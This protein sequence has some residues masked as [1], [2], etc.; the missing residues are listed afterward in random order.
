MDTKDGVPQP[1]AEKDEKGEK[2][3][4]GKTES[5][6]VPLQRPGGERSVQRSVGKQ[7]DIFLTFGADLKITRG[8]VLKDRPPMLARS[9]I[10]RND[11]EWTR[12]RRNKLQKGA[13]KDKG[14]KA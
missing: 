8:S 6:K 11:G 7:K 9:K 1:A 13:K 12:L 14:R 10:R 3:V 2:S 4:K 5:P